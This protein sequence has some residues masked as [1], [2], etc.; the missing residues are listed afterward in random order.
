MPAC[1]RRSVAAPCT[2]AARLAAVKRPRASTVA[3]LSMLVLIT[4]A[5]V[6]RRRRRRDA[7]IP[8]EH[9]APPDDVVGRLVQGLTFSSAA[10]LA[11]VLAPSTQP[12]ESCHECERATNAPQRE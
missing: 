7:A 9:D 10:A 4:G 5:L 1:S 8:A 12:P 3:S 11:G 2:V 6:L